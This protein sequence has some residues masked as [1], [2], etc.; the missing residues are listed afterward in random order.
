MN[1]KSAE[2]KEEELYEPRTRTGQTE[3]KD[4]SD[5]KSSYFKKSMKTEP[6]MSEGIR[7]WYVKSLIYHGE[8]KTSNVRKISFGSVSIQSAQR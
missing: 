4:L 3:V 7:S 8:A 1:S 5:G 6:K 2:Q